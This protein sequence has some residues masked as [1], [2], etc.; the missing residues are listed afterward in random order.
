MTNELK[1]I[2]DFFEEK[3]DPK[4]GF[5]YLKY[6]PFYDPLQL[7]YYRIE[8]RSTVSQK[9][10]DEVFEKIPCYIS[11][12]SMSYMFPD[13][14]LEKLVSAKEILSQLAETTNQ[15]K[16]LNSGN[17]EV[18]SNVLSNSNI[19]YNSNVFTEVDLTPTT[20]E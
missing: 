13:G 7:I 8:G 10:I 20:Y 11:K 4:K 16:I 6:K 19:V 1:D 18:N 5:S 12:D 2:F 17:I 3:T 15:D 9:F 14:V